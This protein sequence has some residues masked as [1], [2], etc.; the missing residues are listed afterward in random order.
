[1]ANHGKTITLTD[2]QQNILSNDLYN[3]PSDNS[4]L[5]AWIDGAMTWQVK[6][7]LETYATRVDYKV[8]E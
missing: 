1:M 6:Q 2:L 4:G 5:D 8:N 7:L 3:D